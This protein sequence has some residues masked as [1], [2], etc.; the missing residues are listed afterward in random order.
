MR[1]LFAQYFH[2]RERERDGR[3]H[4]QMRIYAASQA[5]LSMNNQQYNIRLTHDLRKIPMLHKINCRAGEKHWQGQKLFDRTNSGGKSQN[6]FML[7][8]N[9]FITM[10][11]VKR[12]RKK[13]NALESVYTDSDIE[14]Q[15]C[16][17]LFATKRKAEQESVCLCICGDEEK[18]GNTNTENMKH[19]F[20]LS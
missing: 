9:A 3:R 10:E 8:I 16:G 4:V 6:C 2:R 5:A 13:N 18:N 15:K 19:M 20:V 7:Q 12:E 17:N 11:L 1:F 14:V